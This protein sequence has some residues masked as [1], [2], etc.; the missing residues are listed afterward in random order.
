MAKT[1]FLTVF[2]IT[3]FAILHA[4]TAIPFNPVMKIAGGDITTVTKFP[5]AAQLVYD[6]SGLCTGSIIGDRWIL[7]AAHCLVDTEESKRTGTKVIKNPSKFDINIGQDSNINQN[8]LV[9]KSVYA[10]PE[11]NWNKIGKYDIGL[12]ELSQPLKFTDSIQPVKLIKDESKLSAN[13]PFTAAG[14]GKD[15]TQRSTSKLNR[16]NLF[17]GGPEYCGRINPG[18]PAY[19]DQLLCTKYIHKKTPCSGD[20]GGPLLVEVIDSSGTVGRNA[21]AAWLQAGVIASV[22]NPRRNDFSICGSEDD[23]EFYARTDYFIPWIAQTSGMPIEQ[24][25]GLLPKQFEAY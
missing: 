8:P 5:F 7:T 19:R 3:A 24:F 20:S 17:N 1:D 9:P 14:W 4:A 12:L 21:A 10:H 18:Y 16:V 2:T 15:L 25:T 11:Y 13:Q 22:Y 23:V 6:R